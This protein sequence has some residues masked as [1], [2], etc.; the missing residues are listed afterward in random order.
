MYRL[1][2]PLLFLL[3]A[4][5]AHRLVFFLLKVTGA[6]GRRLLKARAYRPSNRLTLNVAGLKLTS[7]IGL[8]AGMDK[9]GELTQMWPELGFGWIE[10][11]TVTAHPQPGNPKPRMF[12]F[13]A[14]GA[15]VN[16]MGFNNKGSVALASQLRSTPA[17]SVPCGINLGKS[18][19]TPL[20]DAVADYACSAERVAPHADYLVINVSSPNTP[21]LRSLQDGDSL[22]SITEAVVD[23]SNGKP[24]FVKLAP[25]LTE[26]AL[27]DAV[28]V[29]E[30]AGASAII[31]TNT[32]IER[33]GLPDVGPGGLSGRPLHARAVEVVKL[34]SAHTSLPVIGV[35][36]IR[37]GSD[38]LRMLAAGA[39]AV[40]I[41]TALVFEGPQL[42]SSLNQFLEHTMDEHN[43]SSMSELKTALRRGDILVDGPSS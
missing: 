35:G 31:A 41:Y 28:S 36:G 6:L 27:L 13:P 1:L 2:R 21:G 37:C 29:A 24:V 25:D 39:E 12:R 34:V 23:R 3:Q 42:V 4:E 11:G 26:T 8:A 33:H 16:R 14:E 20:D 22:R 40:Q 17:L 32:T 38:V 43:V 19:V 10:L 15:V 7:P 30:R 18:K 5:R 9:D